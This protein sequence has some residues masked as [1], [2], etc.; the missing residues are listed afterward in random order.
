MTNIKEEFERI[1]EEEWPLQDVIFVE[2]SKNVPVGKVLKVDGPYCAVRFPTS[3]QERNRQHYIQLIS[4]P[5]VGELIFFYIASFL[6]SCLQIFNP[7]MTVYNRYPFF[8]NGQLIWLVWFCLAAA[9]ATTATTAAATATT[10]S[11]PGREET[12]KALIDV[13]MK[14]RGRYFQFIL[15][16]G[17]RIPRNKGY[18]LQLKKNAFIKGLEKA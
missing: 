8:W 12:G 1:D 15:F 6:I 3:A 16:V 11:T 18:D 7:S 5:W 4:S 9:A 10:S 2:D 13:Y 17:L 14:G